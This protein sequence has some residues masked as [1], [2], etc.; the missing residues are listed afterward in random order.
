MCGN[1]FAPDDACEED[2][3]DIDG[4]THTRD[5]WCDATGLCCGDDGGGDTG[6]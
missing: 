2:V 4:L 6:E 5:E 1:D 3:Y